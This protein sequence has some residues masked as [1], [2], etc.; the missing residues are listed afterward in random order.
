VD[1]TKL[2]PCLCLLVA[3]GVVFA[4][5]GEIGAP[6]ASS[7]V[8]PSADLAV[9]PI[10]IAD[11]GDDPA[12]VAID[13]GG[14]GFCSGTLVAPDV[15]LTARR[16]V[17]KASS[18]A[19]CAGGWPESA[20]SLAPPSIR[21]L[22]GD[23]MAALQE[24]ARGREVVVPS[25]DAVCGAD[26][27]L[28]LLDTSIDE[29]LPLAVR[30]TG[31]AKGDRL[32]TVDFPRFGSAAALDE[33]VRD[34]VPV[35][36]TTATELGI[37]EGCARAAGGPAIDESTG[38]IVGVASHG[39]ASGCAGV[40]ARH[41]YERTDATLPVIGEALAKSSAPVGPTTGK[42][43]TKKGPIDVGANCVRAGDCAAGVCVTEGLQEYCSRT[44]DPNDRCPTHF[45]CQKTPAGAAVCVQH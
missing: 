1:C 38:E 31:A 42:K 27:A 26:I 12:V 25:G 11:R 36:D 9:P 35:L 21:I 19:P 28:V 2:S 15:V 18:Q 5:S 44:C 8:V 30:A 40:G 14:Q 37:G 41:V 33:L 39:G 16:C 24:R 13:V 43:K 45:R 22:V 32:R 23:G 10:G 4:C 17:A 6:P 3:L 34:H 7:T 29:V 20:S